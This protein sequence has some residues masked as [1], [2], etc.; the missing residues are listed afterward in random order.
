[1]RKQIPAGPRLLALGR[2]RTGRSTPAASRCPT[3]LR[4]T[5]RDGDA[6]DEWR[7]LNDALVPVRTFVP[8]LRVHGQAPNREMWE[9]G[10]DGSPAYQAELKFDRLRYRLLPYVYSL[11][12]ARHAATAGTM[13][14]AAGDGLPRRREG[15][16]RRRPVHVRARAAGQPGDRRTRRAAAQV[17]LPADDGGWYDF[18]TGTRRARRSRAHGAGA[19]RRHAGPR[20]R[21][22][23]RAVR[24]R[25]AVHRR[26][27]GRSDHAVRLRRRD[28]A[29]TL[30]EDDGVSY[31]YE[32]GAFARFRFAGTTRRG[33]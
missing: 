1:M 18:W 31:G 13:H 3:A 29:F 11:A 30:Y 19:V 27:A 4:A 2:C 17:Y 15:A 6:L 20:P 24:S 21:G 32:K 26:E 5:R 23:D 25:A 16:R 10:G 9:L 8:L 7:E 14:A 22:L 12:G 28:G 33:R